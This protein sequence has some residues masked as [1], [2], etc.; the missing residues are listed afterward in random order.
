MGQMPITIA[1]E[2][3]ENKDLF[4]LSIILKNNP[5]L[6][7][8]LENVTLALNE[9]SDHAA[10]II[11]AGAE[12]YKE[13][14]IVLYNQLMALPCDEHYRTTLFSMYGLLPEE[15]KSALPHPDHVF[16]HMLQT[17]KLYTQTEYS[18]S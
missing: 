10:H 7:T 4:V 5:E 17:T 3:E 6:F 12:I 15:Y 8:V 14:Y 13:F 11:H 2:D 1:P 16:E 9:T 18:P